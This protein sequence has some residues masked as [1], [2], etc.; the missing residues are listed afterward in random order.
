MISA[1]S[2]RSDMVAIASKLYPFKLVMHSAITIMLCSLVADQVMNE[3]LFGDSG[4]GEY[5]FGYLPALN[6]YHKPIPDSELIKIS[7]GFIICVVL[8][9]IVGLFS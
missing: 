8:A 5:L 2:E 4:H 9:F 1:S 7:R 6:S 3:V